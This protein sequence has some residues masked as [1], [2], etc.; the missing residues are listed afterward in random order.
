[1]G[2]G[3][4]VNVVPKRSKVLVIFIAHRLICR[5]AECFSEVALDSMD[6]NGKLAN[7]INQSK[8]DAEDCSLGHRSSVFR[9]HMECLLWP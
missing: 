1:M 9:C 2:D 4:D 3:K 6:F 8:I 5:I 7:I